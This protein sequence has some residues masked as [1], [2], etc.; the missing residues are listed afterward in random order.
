MNR[1]EIDFLGKRVVAGC[2]RQCSKAWGI[3]K[4]QRI[5]L[6]EEDDYVYLSDNEL[7]TAPED[8]GTY[9]GGHGKPLTPDAFPN[10]WCVRQCERSATAELGKDLDLP[11]FS[12]RVYNMPWKHKD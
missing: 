9:E 10:A 3:N 1:A 6:G 8:P 11:D 5:E 2:D 12:Q 7:A 4:R